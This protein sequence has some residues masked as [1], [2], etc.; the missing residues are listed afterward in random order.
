MIR[1]AKCHRFNLYV[2]P[3][4]VYKGGS[5]LAG[6]F[7]WLLWLLYGRLSFLLLIQMERNF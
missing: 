6:W 1:S 2:N 3:W 5:G 7:L 4:L